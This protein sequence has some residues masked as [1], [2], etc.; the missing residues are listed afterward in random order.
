MSPSES[1]AA[2]DAAP[3]SAPRPAPR[4]PSSLSPSRADDFMTCPLRYRLRVIDKLPEPPS[5]AA[6]RGAVVHAV[7][8]RLFDVPAGR[9]T[10]DRARALLRPEWERL[11]GR[12]PELAGLFPEDTDGA[13]PAAWLAEAEQLLDQY[14]R[15]EDPN[16]LEPAGRELYVETVL[17]SGLKLRGIIDRVDVAPT[18]EVRVVD[19]KTGKAPPPDFEHRAMFQ[20]KFYALVLWRRRGV[21]PRRLQ[22]V[23]LGSGDVVTYDP[24]EAD[25][26]A[27]ERKLRAL[28]A[29]I[30]RAVA[31]GEWHPSPSRFC[32][33][34]GYQAFCPAFGGTPPPYPLAVATVPAMGDNEHPTA[35]AEA[36]PPTRERLAGG[37]AE[38]DRRPEHSGPA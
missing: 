25:L 12:R 19:Y 13:A 24:D 8:E 6:A 4:T 1:S 31:T 36:E 26:R 17:E 11:L 35:P 16:R 3:P 23:Y 32:D 21:V 2:P 10:P 38:K 27:V 14:F 34:C 15:M 7:L 29:A 33:W 28:W 18:G 9:R 30:Q 5:E 37:G 22:L 20:M